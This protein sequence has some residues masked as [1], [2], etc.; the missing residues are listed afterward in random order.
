MSYTPTEWKTGDVVTSSKL[1]NLETGVENA[2]GGLFK[3]NLIVSSN[4]GNLTYSI[5]KTFAEILEA[6]NS[7]KLPVI[8]VTEEAGFEMLIPFNYLYG[9]ESFQVMEFLKLYV[10][11]SQQI[12]AILRTTLIELDVNGDNMEVIVTNKNYT[13]TENS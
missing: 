8:V 9:D 5:D 2:F 4:S 11:T 7:G 3:I 1:N 6:Y 13:L 10:T 12:G